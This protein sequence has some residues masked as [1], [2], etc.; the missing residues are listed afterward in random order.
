MVYSNAN[1]MSDAMLLIMQVHGTWACRNPS[2]VEK[3]RRVKSLL[4]QFEETHLQYVKRKMNAEADALA[5]EQ[6][7][8]IAVNAIKIQEPLFQGSDTM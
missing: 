2:L 5:E 7:K 3:L 1:S 4:K 6:F 8:D